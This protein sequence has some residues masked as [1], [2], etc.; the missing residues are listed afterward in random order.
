MLGMPF[1]YYP[2]YIICRIKIIDDDIDASSQ[3]DIPEDELF[4]ANEDAPQI[5][6]VIDD[7]PMALRV[8]DYRKND[9]WKPV[10]SVSNSSSGYDQEL[11]RG[12]PIKIT[13]K[14]VLSKNSKYRY[15]T[16]CYLTIKSTP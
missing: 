15:C 14:I 2:I 5:V 8:S 3:F 6:G 10:G 9:V 4:A 7:R 13:H 12:K 11:K 1:I 16:K